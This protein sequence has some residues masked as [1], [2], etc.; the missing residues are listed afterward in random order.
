[1]WC[2][3]RL[4]SLPSTLRHVHNPSQYSDLFRFPWPPTL[5]RWHSP[6]FLFPPTRGGSKGRRLGQL[7]RA[8]RHSLKMLP[9][10]P[11]TIDP[12]LPPTRLWLKHILTFN[13]LLN[14]Y[15]FSGWLLIFLFL[16]SLRLN[17]CSSDSKTNLQNYTTL[18]LPSPTLLIFDEHLTASNQIK[19]LSKACY[20]HISQHRC[21]RPYL[22]SSTVCTTAT[23]IV[24]SKL[25]YCNS[26]YYRWRG[27]T[28]GRV[29]DLQSTGP[30]FKFYSVQK[31]HNNLG[32]VVHTY[33]PLSPNSI[34]QAVQV[35]WGSTCPANFLFHFHFP[36]LT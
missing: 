33:V 18:H 22:D 25:H 35:Q 36:F 12:P 9:R 27:G 17:S 11:E 1:M 2:S 34:T 7:L 8:P 13:T 23:S 14:R 6:L 29:L 32:Q 15:F 31:L 5:C 30:G 19:S 26:P 28:T 4:C 20:Y 21:I 10:A 16:T 24:H 3:Q